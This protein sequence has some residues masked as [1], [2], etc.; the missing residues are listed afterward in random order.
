[1]IYNRA[2]KKFVMWMHIDSGNY[3]AARA[4]VAVSAKPIGPFQYLGSLR[5][6]AGVWPENATAADKD[7]KNTNALARD[8]A[9]G[10]MARDMTLF[11][12]DDGQAYLFYSS[13]E[14]A[15]M[16]VSLLTPDYL[17]P[18]GKYRRIFVGRSLEAPAVFKHGGKYYLIASGCTGW[19][20][21]AAHSAVA[22]S[23]W[24]PWEELGNPCVGENAD[25]TFSSQSTFV[26]LV[27]GPRPGLVFM[28]DR[29]KKWD[30]AD[31]RY[32]WL[33]LEFNASG[34]PILRYRE[35]WSLAPASPAAA[36]SAEQW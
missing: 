14:N 7:P 29:W 3:A 25:K 17:S 13:E 16:H 31:S 26:L 4:G 9:K 32:V 19:N 27:H 1:V 33:P 18:A 11:L 35:R 36:H 21:N 34:K 28:A 24:G 10:Q 6:N 23:P 30:L 5:P 8:F 20:P 12:D 15:T 22:D 2:T